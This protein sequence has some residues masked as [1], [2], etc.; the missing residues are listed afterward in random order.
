LE[1]R[2][3]LA[4]ERVCE[5]Y[6]TEEVADFLGVD[7]SSVR[8][9]VAAF[10]VQGIAALA[11]RPVPGRPPRLT[12]AQEKIVCRW[13]ADSP[14]DHGF[15]TELWSAPRLGLLIEQEFNV[16]FHPNYLV[17]WMRQ[18]GYTPQLPAASPAK[19]TSARSPA[20]WPRTGRG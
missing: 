2:R 7:P 18:R 14:I 8:R 5:G 19:P 4:V 12:P 20:G 6:S 16:R 11:A 13:L 1:H 15:A 17:A 3:Q 10:Q 9:W